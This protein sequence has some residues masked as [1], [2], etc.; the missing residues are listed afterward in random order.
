MYS[1][2]DAIRKTNSNSALKQPLFSRSNRSLLAGHD[3]NERTKP[4]PEQYDPKGSAV[5]NFRPNKNQ[6]GNTGQ[7]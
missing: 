7:Q 2:D 6:Q 1:Q 5:I 4:M 3:K